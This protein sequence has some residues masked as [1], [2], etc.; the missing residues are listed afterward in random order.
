MVPCSPT[1]VWTTAR[2]LFAGPHDSDHPNLDDDEDDGDV[3]DDEEEDDGDDSSLMTMTR[4]VIT[5]CKETSGRAFEW[6]D[7]HAN[8]WDRHSYCTEVIDDG[9]DGDI[10]DD[11][12]IYKWTER[13][14]I[15]FQK[16][17]DSD[18]DWKRWSSFPILSILTIVGNLVGKILYHRLIF[19]DQKFNI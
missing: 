2:L 11:E 13:L 5:E 15:I 4:S 17:C 18:V 19:F 9:E 10:D 16:K 14:C 7:L 12:D 1:C 3:E 6:R 8:Q